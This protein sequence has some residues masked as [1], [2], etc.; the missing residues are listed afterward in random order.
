MSE[1]VIIVIIIIPITSITYAPDHHRHSYHF[2]SY[3]HYHSCLGR[4]VRQCLSPFTHFPPSRPDSALPHVLPCPFLGTP[5][6]LHW[7]WSWSWFLSWSHCDD[8]GHWVSVRLLS[9][10]FL[11]SGQTQ[12]PL[13]HTQPC[14]SLGSWHPFYPTLP[15]W[16]QCH[17]DTV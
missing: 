17:D 6:I 10:T 3:N 13:G 5:S 9:H 15:S 1:T 2:H 12:P 16:S 11:P 8:I 14:P 4:A 7:C